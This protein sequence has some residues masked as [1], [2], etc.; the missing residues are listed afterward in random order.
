MDLS[1]WALLVIAVVAL[2]GACLLIASDIAG[3]LIARPGELDVGIVTAFVGAP[4]FIWIV[5][6]ARV[7]EL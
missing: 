6:R 7:R 2:V 1:T 5:R 4:F 3:R